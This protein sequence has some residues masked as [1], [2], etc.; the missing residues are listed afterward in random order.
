LLDAGASLLRQP[1]GDIEWYVLA[2]PE[3]N[4]FCAFVD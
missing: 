3:D 2:D 1:D 4:E